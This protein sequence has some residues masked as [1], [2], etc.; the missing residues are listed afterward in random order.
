MLYNFFLQN[1][2]F[3]NFL[4]FLPTFYANIPVRETFYYFVIC[5]KFTL[6]FSQDVQAYIAKSVACI[7]NCHR[8]IA[9]NDLLNT[10]VGINKTRNNN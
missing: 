8:H 4:L 10:Y 3:G 2:P 9:F 7:Y 6:L 5:M 1:T